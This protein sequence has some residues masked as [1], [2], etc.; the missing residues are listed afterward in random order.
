MLVLCTASKLHPTTSPLLAAPVPCGATTLL[1]WLLAKEEHYPVGEWWRIWHQG[2]GL[3][4]WLNFALQR[5]DVMRARTS[6]TDHG[7][8]DAGLN[9]E[10]DLC[11]LDWIN[12][13]ASLSCS[14]QIVLV[15]ISH[16]DR[17]NSC[18][19]HLLT[20]YNPWPERRLSTLGLKGICT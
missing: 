12:V 14:L 13:S 2:G 3:T 7:R 20:V 16:P 9:L 18:I 17:S 10:A 6:L 5:F 1:C 4:L 15:R 19:R 8:A 11:L